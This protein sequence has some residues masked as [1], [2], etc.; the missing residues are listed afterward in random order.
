ME[1]SEVSAELFAAARAGDVQRVIWS[2]AHDADVNW[3]CVAE[4]KKTAVHVAC[5][6]GHVEVLEC[7]LLNSA[8]MLALDEKDL[9]PL[10]YAQKTETSD[11]CVSVL[12]LHS[13]G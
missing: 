5:E 3:A 11:D 10:D 9:A 7:L 8:N 13:H 2:I 12:I 6:M 4:Q 1:N